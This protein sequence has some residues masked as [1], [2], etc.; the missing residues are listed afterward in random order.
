M[1]LNPAETEALVRC[2]DGLADFESVVLTREDS[3]GNLLAEDG[4]LIVTVKWSD[5]LVTADSISETGSTVA[6]S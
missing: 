4:F 2:I 3:L 1:I 5:G 6:W